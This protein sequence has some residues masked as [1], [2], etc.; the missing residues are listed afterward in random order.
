[1]QILLYKIFS[2]Y[3]VEGSFICDEITKVLSSIKLC[4][5]YKSG[6]EERFCKFSLTGYY[7]ILRTTV[8][9]NE[10]YILLP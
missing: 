8:L 2:Y 5:H 10:F 7:N 4:S 3:E 1:M 9:L 6:F